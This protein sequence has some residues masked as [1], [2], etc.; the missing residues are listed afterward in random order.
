MKSMQNMQVSRLHR[1]SDQRLKQTSISKFD[2][3]GALHR[4]NYL[5]SRLSMNIENL[6]NVVALRR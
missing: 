4:F 1:V 2:L 5:L 3:H 6:T